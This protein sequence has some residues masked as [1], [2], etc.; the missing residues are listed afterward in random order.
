MAASETG[1]QPPETEAHSHDSRKGLPVLDI[2]RNLRFAFDRQSIRRRI[3]H[4]APHRVLIDSYDVIGER[5]NQPLNAFFKVRYNS[6]V[7]L[8][9][10]VC[11]AWVLNHVV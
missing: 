2:D 11:L 9:A 1:G 3:F 6:R 4:L 5:T 8:R 10:V 7:P